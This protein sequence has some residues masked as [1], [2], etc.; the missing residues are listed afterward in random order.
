MYL[1]SSTQLCRDNILHNRDEGKIQ[2][3]KSGQHQLFPGGKQGGQEKGSPEGRE[4]IAGG[5]YAWI[6][7]YQVDKYIMSIKLHVNVQFIECQFIECPENKS[8]KYGIKW[9]KQK[10][11]NQPRSRI[12]SHHVD[13]AM[14][15]HGIW[16]VRESG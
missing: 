7:I 5:V 6:L 2:A 3:K 1:H 13:E 10:Q 12:W 8:E 15:A 14:D 4:K 11:Q 16:C 9:L